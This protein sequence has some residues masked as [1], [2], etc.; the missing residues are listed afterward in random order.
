MQR[1]HIALGVHPDGVLHV[2]VKD[3]FSLVQHDAPVAQL[4]D[5][6][7]IVAD[8]KDSPSLDLSDLPHF[9]Q[10]L[11][12]EIHVADRQHL[13]HDH[14]LA[15][16]MRSDGEG[17]LDE[18]AGGIPLH[19]G[20][21][22]VPHL[23]KFDDVLHFGVDLCFGHA[24]DRT[25]HVDILPAGHFPVE[26]GSHLQHGGNT[27]VD[28]NLTLG[29]RG[30]AAQQ[31]QKRAF[32]RA[33]AADD[34]QRLALVYRQVNAVQRH[35]GLSYQALIHIHRQIGVFLS[36]HT[37]PPALQVGGQRAAAD[38]PQLIALFHAGQADGNILFVHNPPSLH[39]IHKG[40]FHLVEDHNAQQRNYQRHAP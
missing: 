39:R 26:P 10:T 5:G 38:L 21:D 4:P 19:R 11:L 37:R 40:A 27:A 34:A 2:S 15:V 36:P 1:Q 13:V 28:V 31:L 35:K 3:N 16:Q 25:V 20:V 32:S 24:Q 22:K 33:V 17:Q 7:H 29:G 30:D 18:H 6:A 14:D 9:F 23:G 12:L 8:V